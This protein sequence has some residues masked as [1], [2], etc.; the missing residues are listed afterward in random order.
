M[1][2][3]T[4]LVVVMMEARAP[5]EK[6][7]EDTDLFPQDSARA[8]TFSSRILR[9][10]P[11]PL[12]S[13]QSSSNS[14]TCSKPSF[15]RTRIEEGLSVSTGEDAEQG[16]I[17]QDVRRNERATSQRT[18]S[19]KGLHVPELLPSCESGPR[20]SRA[21][22]SSAVGRQQ[23][24]AEV[25][26]TFPKGEGRVWVGWVDT[27]GANQAGRAFALDADG[28]QRVGVERST[29]ASVEMSKQGSRRRSFPGDRLLTVCCRKAAAVTKRG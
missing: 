15:C 29:V 16:R 7:R 26:A 3:P 20:G 6:G 11:P 21:D 5:V 18:E 1:R 28:G 14:A 23:H 8:S 27:D 22:P 19:A 12:A 2:R 25:P 9:R 17:G 24:I 13:G 10:V 4:L